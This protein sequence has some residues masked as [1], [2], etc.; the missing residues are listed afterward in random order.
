MLGLRKGWSAGHGDAPLLR[1]RRLP[2]GGYVPVPRPPMVPIVIPF[3]AFMT[4]CSFVGAAILIR[5]FRRWRRGE[6][7]DWAAVRYATVNGGVVVAIALLV[8]GGGVE[9]WGE[10][11]R[12]TAALAAL[13]VHGEVE[14]AR[15]K[16][17]TAKMQK[18]EP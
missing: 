15:H 17:R 14:I 3:Q 5:N 13:L 10:A 1:Q 12:M 18:L 2:Y 6:P 16:N 4:A 8:V 7:R 9:S 11:G